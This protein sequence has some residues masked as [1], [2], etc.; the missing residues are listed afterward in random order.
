MTIRF[1]DVAKIYYSNSIIIT[2][3]VQ[4]LIPSRWFEIIFPTYLALK[5]RNKIFMCYLENLSYTCS[6]YS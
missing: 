2:N 5:Y 1:F 6:N 3:F 4:T